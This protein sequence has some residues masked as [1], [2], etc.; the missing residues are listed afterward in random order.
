MMKLVMSQPPNQR[1]M[2]ERLK[3]EHF[4]KEKQKERQ[5]QRRVKE[6]RER[7]DKIKRLYKKLASQLHPDKGGSDDDFQRLNESY[8]KNDLIDLLTAG[9]YGLEYEID[10]VR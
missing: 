4:V 6:S 1:R 2:I 8:H 10:E 7:P 3:E 5:R 9:D